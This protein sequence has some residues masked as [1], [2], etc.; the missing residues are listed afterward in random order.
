MVELGIL[1][2]LGSGFNFVE[3]MRNLLRNFWNR[4]WRETKK[5]TLELWESIAAPF[6]WIMAPFRFMKAHPVA[7]MVIG[8]ASLPVLGIIALFLFAVLS[9]PVIPEETPEAREWRMAGDAPQ[10]DIQREPRTRRQQD[11]ADQATLARA[12]PVDLPPNYHL[13]PAVVQEAYRST[14]GD[15]TPTNPAPSEP[16]RDA[17]NLSLL[18]QEVAADQ[19]AS[20]SSEPAEPVGVG[21]L[22]LG[23]ALQALNGQLHKQNME[24]SMM[25][26]EQQ[27]QYNQWQNGN[28]TVYGNGTVW[29]D[30]QPIQF[31]TQERIPNQYLQPPPPKPKW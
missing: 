23:A 4:F 7:S 29:L 14:Q 17:P 12:E 31:Q 11:K 28:T 25:Y 26:N 21:E 19:W 9:P 18:P 30:G 6:K 20:T 27:R 16:R 24:R 10:N 15:R 1:P 8:I 22:I 5:D 2:R 3:I 13:L